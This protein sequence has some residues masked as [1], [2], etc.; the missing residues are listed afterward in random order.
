MADHLLRLQRLCGHERLLPDR[1]GKLF[2]QHRLRHHHCNRWHH[3][4]A[5]PHS[6]RLHRS[7]AGIRLRPRQHPFRQAA[8]SA[9]QRLPDRSGG[10]A[11]YVQPVF[12]QGLRPAGVR[13]DLH[14]LY[15]RLYRQQHDHP[16]PAGYYD[17]RSPP[18]SHHRCLDHCAELLRA[19]GHEH[20]GLHRHPAQVRRHLQS[21]LPQHGLHHRPDHCRHRHPDRLRRHLRLR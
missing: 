14:Y 16:D 13:F 19:H 3:P 21:G 17:Q 11:V 1:Y 9:D 20:A 18:A 7:D 4:D 12:Q 5:G 10:P 8:R 6:G 2:C 15:Y